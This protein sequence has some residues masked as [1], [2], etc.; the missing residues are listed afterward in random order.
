MVHEA[1]ETA[2][3]FFQ[4]MSTQPLALALIISNFALIG[5]LYYEGASVNQQRKGE[6]ELLYA[7]RREVALL[8]AR[9]H[10][11]EGTPLPEL[12][13]QHLQTPIQE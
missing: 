9:C 7:N 13:M 5:Y 6:L 1:G 12:K 10:W 4:V 8:L 2:R 3:S 11:P